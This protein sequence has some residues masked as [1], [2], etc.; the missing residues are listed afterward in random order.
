[1][2]SPRVRPHV[3]SQAL[4]KGA[5][6]LGGVRSRGSWLLV[7]LAPWGPE[8]LEGGSRL[9]QPQRLLERTG[10][11]FSPMALSKKSKWA[12]P[13]WCAAA[14]IRRFGAEAWDWGRKG[15]PTSPHCPF[16][17]SCHGS[18]HLERDRLPLRLARHRAGWSHRWDL[19]VGAECLG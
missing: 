4:G 13:E 6:L 8:L 11:P 15:R 5:C 3:P 1:M 17:R 18:R 12:L 9:G 19:G 10:L 2:R 16:L 14:A 7:S